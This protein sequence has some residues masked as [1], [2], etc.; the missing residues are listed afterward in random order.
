[1]KERN[2]KGGEKRTGHGGQGVGKRKGEGG[3]EGSFEESDGDM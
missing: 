3:M 2:Y 1:M